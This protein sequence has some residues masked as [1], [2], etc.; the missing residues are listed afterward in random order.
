MGRRGDRAE[1]GQQTMI[2]DA[3]GKPFPPL[4]VTPKLSA[5]AEYQAADAR[6]SGSTIGRDELQS[7]T[8]RHGVEAG[9]AAAAAIARVRSAAVGRPHH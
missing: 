1:V 8:D 2:L 9:L 5:S 6:W 3:A 7:L 4:L